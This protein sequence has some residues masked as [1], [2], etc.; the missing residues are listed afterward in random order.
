[1]EKDPGKGAAFVDG[2]AVPIAEAKIPMLDWGFLHS[3]ATYDVVHVWKGSFFRLPDHLDRFFAGMRSLRMSIEYD[4][5]QVG[6]ILADCVRASGLRNAYVEMICT[7]GLPKPGSRDP[8]E[9]VNSFYA[10]A[11]P[12]VWIADPARQEQGMHLAV[13]DIRRISP[14]SV[15]PCVKNYHWLDMVAALFQGYD[16][17]AETTVLVGDCGEL[18]EGPGFNV[19]VANAGRLAT[20]ESGVLEGVTRRT[21]MEL[22][23]KK[24][25]PVEKRR[26]APEEAGAADE[27][28]ITSTAG[29]VMPVTKVDG[30]RIG[31]GRPGRMTMELTEAYWRL[32]EDPAHS[33]PVAY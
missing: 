32:H 31:D 26:I 10:F 30:A 19:F 23:A 28:F 1:M 6:G 20:P 29:G 12:F 16:R 17:G 3:D 25:I 13:S 9:C 15:D 5:E 21:V 27:V 8:R 14:R 11:V 22:A 4:R 2:R 33:T 24:G 18:V 7:R